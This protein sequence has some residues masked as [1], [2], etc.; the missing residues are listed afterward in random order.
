M[1]DIVRYSFDTFVG[2]GLFEVANL[3]LDKLELK[4]VNFNDNKEA[5]VDS[6]EENDVGKI[7][8]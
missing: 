5:D 7:K 1:W 6:V 8:D 3:S 4:S 2:I